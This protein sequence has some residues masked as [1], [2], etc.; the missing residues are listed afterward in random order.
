M[1]PLQLASV[2][3]GLVL[4]GSFALAWDCNGHRAIT[5]LGL[6]GMAR[7]APDEPSFLKDQAS[8]MMAASDGCEPDRYRSIKLLYMAHEN[9]PDHYLDVEDLEQ[10]GLTLDTIPPLRNEYLRDLI[11]AKHTHPDNVKPYNELMDPARQQEWPGT[12]PYAV[13]EHYAKLTAEFKTWRV[14]DRLN[15]PSRVVQLEA[16]RANVLMEMGQLSH[17]VGDLAQPLHT[18]SHH[19]GW[20]DDNPDGFTTDRR[21]HS[22]ID[23]DILVV[24]HLEYETL[25]PAC[26]FD[27]TVDAADPWKDVVEH[28]RRSHDQVRPLYQLQK[29]GELEGEP[30]KVFITERLCDGGSMLAA[31]YAAAWKASEIN[32]N[33]VKDFIK[34]DRWG[35]VKDAP[36]P[37]P[38]PRGL[39]TKG[40]QATPASNP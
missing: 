7:L 21:F 25:A 31:M 8:R 39:Q 2:V 34:Y 3:A 26:E 20:V 15:D 32:D 16:A 18:T 30:G 24:H 14:L 13:M 1:K 5:L 28:I 12:A 35:S 38:L 9:N 27:R 22:Y 36:K 10:F 23:G 29:S 40:E 4:S 19:H 37:K 17:F 33:D 6:D 11:I